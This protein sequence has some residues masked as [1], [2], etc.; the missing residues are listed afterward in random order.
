MEIDVIHV[1]N[2]RAPV[3]MIGRS[4]LGPLALLRPGQPGLTMPVLAFVL[5][6]PEAGPLV[7]DTG[8]HAEAI[9]DLLSD[10]GRVPGLFFGRMAPCGTAFDVQL[11]ARG[12]DPEAVERVVMTHLHADHTSGMR[13]LP[14]ARFVLDRREWEA[15]N[16]P[17]AAFDGYAPRHLPGPIRMEQLDLERGEAHGPFSSTLDLLGDGSVRL[18][19]TPGH[20]AGH[21]SVLVDDRALIVGDAVYTLSS[22]ESGDLPWK[23]HDD[24]RYLETVRELQ[25]FRRERPDAVVAPTHDEHAWKSLR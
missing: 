16:R 7:V 17:R 14:N 6:H 9:D 4:R 19:S 18:I 13:S 5:R 1:A 15:A 22:L 21:L 10:Y 2:L 25:A 11:R 23:T 12:V 24:E 8:L 20:S 3:A